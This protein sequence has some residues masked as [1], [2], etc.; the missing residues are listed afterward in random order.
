MRD[1]GLECYAAFP[2]CSSESDAS[3]ATIIF[4]AGKIDELDIDTIITIEGSAPDIARS[5][6]DNTR[7]R[8]MNIVTL[9]SMQSVSGDLSGVSYLDIMRSNFAVTEQA[10]GI[11]S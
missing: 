4:L 1:Y 3:F 10:L 9:N 2:G 7:R 11:N 8:D 5:V 6:R